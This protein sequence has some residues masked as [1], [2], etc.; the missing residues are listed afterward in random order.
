[1]PRYPVDP[2]RLSGEDLRRWYT[3]TPAEI[4]QQRQ[5]EVVRRHRAFFGGLRSPDL[6]PESRRDPPLLDRDQET[7]TQPSIWLASD[8]DPGL[9]GNPVGAIR[10]RGARPAELPSQSLREVYEPLR[11]DRGN[12]GAWTDAS[13]GR[14]SSNLSSSLVTGTESDQPP[15]ALKPAHH[16]I[17]AAGRQ[18]GDLDPSRTE[19]F[20]PGEDGKHYPVPGWRTTGPF[21]ID[22]WLQRIDWDGVAQDLAGITTGALTFLEGGGLGAEVLNGLGYRIGPGFVRG[23]IEGH[24]AL[25]KFMGGPNKQELAALFQSLHREFHL[26][27]SAALRKAGFPRVGGKGGGTDDWADFFGKNIGKRD[28]ALQ[29]L[30]D[31]TRSFDKRRGTKISKYLDAALTQS[32][33]PPP[34]PPR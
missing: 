1:M 7:R 12:G 14:P 23:I 22:D 31:V 24:H 27:L 21:A 5:A 4:E 11:Q 28:E 19:V 30:Q 2:S 20:E 17:W 29:I 26:E 13:N 16:A 6:H 32:K 8:D 25:P 9:T 3:Q 33:T 15:P 10:D 34:T 18:P